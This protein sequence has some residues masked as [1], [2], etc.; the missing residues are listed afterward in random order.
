MAAGLPLA[1][2]LAPA[3]AD[4][5]DAAN[6]GLIADH[7]LASQLEELASDNEL[8]R[9]LGAAN[10]LR[11]QQQFDRTRTIARLRELCQRVAG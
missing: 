10:R 5:P 9:E 4:L 3:I 2:Q 8:R 6:R 11:A 7:P 1:G